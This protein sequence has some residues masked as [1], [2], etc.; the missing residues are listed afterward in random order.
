MTFPADLQYSTDHEWVRADGDQVTVGIT[1][2]AAEALGDVVYLELPGVGTTVAA[3]VPCG[4][5]ESTK[6]V[7]DLVAPIDG[8]VTA[9]NEE[10]T[11][12]PGVVNSDPYVAGWLIRLAP[13]ASVELMTATQ[14]EVFVSGGTP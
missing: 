6:S 1:S 3:G 9:T 10:L 14:Y 5:I 4:E 2:Y 13:S 8:V 11:R 7:S 12:E